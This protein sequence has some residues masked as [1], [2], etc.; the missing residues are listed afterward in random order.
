MRRALVALLLVAAA[1]LAAQSP[2]AQAAATGPLS[3]HVQGAV[4]AALLLDQP[5]LTVWPFRAEETMRGLVDFANEFDGTLIAFETGDPD[6]P[7]V[8]GSVYTTE[9]PPGA[10]TFACATTEFGARGEPVGGACAVAGVI[11]GRGTFRISE[12][13]LAPGGSLAWDVTFP[14]VFCRDC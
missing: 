10:A 4:G 9:L 12:L 7:L 5:P 6:R 11:V 3:V 8:T 14:R 13:T 1:V 2:P